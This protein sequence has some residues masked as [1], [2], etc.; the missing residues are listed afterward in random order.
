MKI[1][2]AIIVEGRDDQAALSR[3]CDCFS[4]AT[5]GFGIRK[6]T[7]ELIQRAYEAQGIIIFTDPDFAG[8]KI[9]E[10]LAKQFPNAKQAFLTRGEARK[11][12]D[13]GIENAAPQDILAALIRAGATAEDADISG[14]PGSDGASF[15]P[16]EPENAVTQE[17]LFDLGLAGQ[18]DSAA[19]RE[20]AGK[21]LRIGS[22]NAKSFLK[23]LNSFKI[24]REELYTACQS[25]RARTK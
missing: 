16:A 23:K 8:K 24:S 11:D 6:E 3:A 18:P 17:D 21:A 20:A 9:R 19:L 15:S 7:V 12:G 13:I 5:H 1:K 25:F 10:R 14:I 4:I 2:E 22:G